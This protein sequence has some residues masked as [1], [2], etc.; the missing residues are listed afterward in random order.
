MPRC[1]LHINPWKIH[2][3][4]YLLPP[5]LP[6]GVGILG[7]VIARPGIRVTNPLLLYTLCTVT[8]MSPLACAM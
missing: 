8:S 5:D 3:Y 6:E 4:K 1:I 2:F 7:R